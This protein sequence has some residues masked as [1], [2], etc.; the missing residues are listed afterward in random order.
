MS[1][2]RED[3]EAAYT[4]LDDAFAAVAALSYDTLTVTEKKNLLVR[5]ETHRR[6]QPAAEHPLINQLSTGC[7]PET[8][9]GTSLVDVLATCLRI[10]KD[11]AKRR[12]A[13]ADDLGPRTAMSGEPLD[14]RLPATA[15]AQAAG[16]IGFEHVK[17][18]RNFFDKLPAAVDVET[19]EQAEVQL[20]TS[21]TGLGPVQLRAAADRLAQ[22]LDQDGPAPTDVDRARQRSFTVSKP[23]PD[24]MC[25]VRGVL[26][27]EAAAIWNAVGAKWAAPG[28]CNPDDDVPTVDGPPGESA[29]TKDLRSQR[30]RNHD[31]FKAMGRALLAS[32]Q[33]GKHNGLPVSIIVSTTLSELESAAGHA[34]TAGGSLLPMA[35]VI[36]MASHA[37]H[38]LVIFEDHTKIPLYLG[39]SKRVASPGQR[40]VLHARDRGCT[41]PGCTVPG[42]GCQ[43]H[44]GKKPWARGGQTNVDEEVLACPPHNRLV[45]KGGWITRIRTDGTVEWIPPPHLDNGQARTNNYHFPE[46]YLL[47]DDGRDE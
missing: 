34:V 9:G 10:S 6:R 44:H 32:G 15:A 18:I 23:G 3:I 4:K 28:M 1:S 5:L 47:P 14:P 19:R 30:Q 26:D 25:E 2:S 46:N 45:E 24:G 33:L 22:I 7:M 13:E 37:H 40:I 17:T 21:A 12:I 11:E 27:P 8:L 41:F 31:A 36:R 39:R 20:A 29:S 35:D 16:Q 42:Y 43:A 38:Y